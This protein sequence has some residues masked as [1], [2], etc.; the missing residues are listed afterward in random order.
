MSS[1]DK[2]LQQSA[3]M[4]RIF[5]LGDEASVDFI[6]LAPVLNKGVTVR[7]MCEVARIT[8]S[9]ARVPILASSTA[10]ARCVG[11]RSLHC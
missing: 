9:L 4:I 5:G 3:R 7:D 1:P 2:G 8:R 6:Y 10:T 11:I